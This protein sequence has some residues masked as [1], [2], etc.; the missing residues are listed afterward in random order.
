MASTSSLVIVQVF[1]LLCNF[2]GF[3]ITTA[4]PLEPTEPPATPQE[5]KVPKGKKFVK[6]TKETPFALTNLSPK[7]RLDLFHP[8]A[9]QVHVDD[10]TLRLPQ[11]NT[12]ELNSPNLLKKHH[13]AVQKMAVDKQLTAEQMNKL[14]AMLA[15]NMLDYKKAMT[16]VNEYKKM[17]AKLT[18]DQRRAEENKLSQ[19]AKALHH[20]FYR[21][22]MFALKNGDASKP[23]AALR[24]VIKGPN[25]S[26][27]QRVALEAEITEHENERKAYFQLHDEN[28]ANLK[29]K[30]DSKLMP[31]G[32]YKT[33]QEAL[34]RNVAKRQEQTGIS[35]SKLKEKIKKIHEADL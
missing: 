7:Q 9:D 32:A 35:F 14:R 5:P 1:V 19:E 13:D 23:Y 11:L 30:I 2:H 31:F 33:Q 20:K 18:G 29:E 3:T 21:V 28:I 15:E 10:L 12:A 26:E 24:Q 27:E 34:K 25:F 16:K 8:L 4:V 6:K 17:R 22:K